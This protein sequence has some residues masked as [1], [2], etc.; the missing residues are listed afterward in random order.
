MQSFTLIGLLEQRTIHKLTNSTYPPWLY[1][2]KYWRTCPDCRKASL[3]T[4]KKMSNLDLNPLKL[5]LNFIMNKKCIFGQL[6]GVG[7]SKKINKIILKINLCL[8]VYKLEWKCQERHT[9]T[10]NTKICIHVFIFK[11]KAAK[12][13][14]L[15]K[16]NKYLF[17]I[18]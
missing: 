2:C 12:I 9:E 10:Q 11:Y 8:E 17:G 7:V 1:G 18:F 4:F 5:E 6:M 3:L 15:S 13:L 14:L 16:W